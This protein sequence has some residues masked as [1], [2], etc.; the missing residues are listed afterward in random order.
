MSFLA[1][2]D[3]LKSAEVPLKELDSVS[4]EIKSMRT[5]APSSDFNVFM[6]KAL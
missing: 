5:R 4:G 6:T 2:V 3:D 1:R